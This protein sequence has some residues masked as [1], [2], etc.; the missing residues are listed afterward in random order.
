MYFRKTIDAYYY[1][2]KKYA[3]TSPLRGDLT[4]DEKKESDAWIKLLMAAELVAGSITRSKK[5]K[6]CLNGL[7][8]EN[9]KEM[10]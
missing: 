9:L 2:K 8:I 10:E 7:S 4:E 5:Y 3:D 1:L 6:E